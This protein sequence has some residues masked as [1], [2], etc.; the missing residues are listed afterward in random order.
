M[1]LI[2]HVQNITLM[3]DRLFT[4]SLDVYYF[5]VV[6]VFTK[7]WINNILLKFIIPPRIMLVLWMEKE[8]WSY[9][10]VIEMISWMSISSTTMMIN[11][12]YLFPYSS[13]RKYLL[14]DGNDGINNGSYGDKEYVDEELER[15]LQVIES[16]RSLG[17][18]GMLW[19]I[20]LFGRDVD[21]GDSNDMIRS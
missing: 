12:S 16:D 17:D 14:T 3:W 20:G 6:F 8:M 2:Q 21:A 11:D 19:S 15:T 5:S 1:T 9:H 18:E 4:L 7:L 10:K 13:W